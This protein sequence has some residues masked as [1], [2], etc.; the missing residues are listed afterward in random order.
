M[1]NSGDITPVM[2]YRV[3]HGNLDFPAGCHPKVAVMLCGINNFG[4]THSAGGKEKWDLGINCPPEDIAHGQQAIAQVFRRKLP[5]TRVI[6]LALLPVADPEKWA[7]C[8]RVNAIQAAIARNPDEVAYV[9]LQ[10][11]FLGPDGTIKREWFTDGLHL[12]AKGYQAWVDGLAPVIG[13][14]MAAP[15]LAPARIMLIGGSLTEGADSG[16]CYR[17]YLDGMLR[18]KGRL[19]D[20]VGSRGKHRDNTVMP[21]SDQ[22]DPD[23]EGHWGKDSRWFAENMPGLLENQPPD[24]AVIE[25]GNEDIASANDAAE[26]LTEGIVR[27]IKRVVETLRSKNPQVKIVL[28]H[29]IANHGKEQA[30]MLLNRK[31]DMLG[32]AGAAGQPPM[33]VADTGRGFDFKQDMDAS[34]G[35][36]N[37]AGARKIAAA[38]ADAIDP[39][40]PRPVPNP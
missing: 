2:L 5:T 12:S 11:R 10:D 19:I 27:H 36:P 15:P 16:T 33:V 28:A 37:A 32:R 17:R 21:D 18:R 7:R 3:T 14:F 4:V 13:K 38:L 26:P 39:L 35:L 40:L 25:L 30:A 8:R 34:G 9:D 23:H 29:A 20:L 1:G 22:F 6:M 31:L 24:V